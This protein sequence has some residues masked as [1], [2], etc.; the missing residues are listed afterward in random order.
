M[1]SHHCQKNR[2]S[3][4]KGIADVNCLTSLRSNYSEAHSCLRGHVQD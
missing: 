4:A 2:Y 3:C 1:A